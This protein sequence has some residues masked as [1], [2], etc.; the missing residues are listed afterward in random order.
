RCSPHLALPS[1]PTRRSSDLYNIPARAIVDITVAT[2]AQLAA[3][4]RV[5]G[6]KDA[7][8]DLARPTRE[9]LRIGAHFIRLSGEDA[10]AVAYNAADRKSTRL[11][12][13][14]VK[15]SYAV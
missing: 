3:L 11:N 12:S 10:T 2:M 8:C 9:G 4:G 15:I 7:T 1:F 13:S 5:V 6:V 14:H